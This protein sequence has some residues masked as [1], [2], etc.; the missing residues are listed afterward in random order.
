MWKEQDI[1]GL[2]SFDTADDHRSAIERNQEP[3]STRTLELV[4]EFDQHLTQSDRTEDF[5]FVRAGICRPHS[6]CECR[7]NS[8]EE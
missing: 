3:V 2:T 1:G 8:H 4:C 6:T 7:H 5:E